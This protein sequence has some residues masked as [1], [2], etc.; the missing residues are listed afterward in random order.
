MKS[1]R[2]PL[3]ATMNRNLPPMHQMA[4]SVPVRDLPEGLRQAYTRQ[5][6]EELVK[7][8]N[9]HDVCTQLA[10]LCA[11]VRG[12][13]DPCTRDDP[14]WA[15]ACH[16]L[17]LGRAGTSPPNGKG[18]LEAFCAELMTIAPA[19]RYHDIDIGVLRAYRFLLDATAERPPDD[20]ASMDK[21][22]REMMY[23]KSGAVVFAYAASMSMPLLA[24]AAAGLGVVWDNEDNLSQ[25]NPGASLAGDAL[26]IAC[27]ILWKGKLRT[28]S[29]SVAELATVEYLLS[30]PDAPINGSTIEIH[31]FTDNSGGRNNFVVTEERYSVPLWAAVMR[32]SPDIVQM[33]L[34]NGADPRLSP[35]NKNSILD[36]ANWIAAGNH[37]TRESA[38]ILE[39]IEEAVEKWNAN[40]EE[41]EE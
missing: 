31:T 27:G 22:Y 8:L 25:T 23:H 20:F 26:Y 28:G 12:R 41:M 10:E 7:N 33:L 24:E 29:V 4:L 37:A 13:N 40:D 39:A 14:I 17:G 11:A 35:T 34:E 6:V 3:P 1:L 18:K 21:Y 19:S 32:Q 30:L 36:S 38:D 2:P 16:R 9:F 5:I 15:A